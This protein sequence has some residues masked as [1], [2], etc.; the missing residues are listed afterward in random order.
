MHTHYLIR[1]IVSTVVLGAALAVSGV[2]KADAASVVDVQPKID[3]CTAAKDTAHDMAECARKLGLPE[4]HTAIKTAQGIWKEQDALHKQYKAEYNTLKAKTEARMKQYPQATAIYEK[5][6]ARGVPEVATCAI[7]ANIMREVGGDTLNISPL[8]YGGAGGYYGMCQWSL[9]YNPSVAGASVDGQ[10]DYLMS[11]IEGN[12]RMFGGSYEYFKS[13]SD[14][15]A[16]ARYF[17]DYYERG[18]HG[19]QRVANGYRAYEYFNS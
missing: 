10:I 16:A 5:L 9:Y 18:A 2:V 3:A 11:T 6:R 19:D 13:M 12:M 7:M 1:T 8:I 14:V 15:G 4:S 17:N